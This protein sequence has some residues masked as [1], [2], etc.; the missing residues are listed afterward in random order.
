MAHP[1]EADL[2]ALLQA[3]VGSGIEFIVVGGAA[4][5]LQGAP[6]TTQDLDIVHRRTAG[7]VARLEQL[8]TALDARIR[9]PAGRDLRPDVSHLSGRGQL[10]LS[11]SLGPLDPRCEIHDGRGYEELLPRSEILTDGSTR[12][13]V[14]DLPTPIEVK[15]SA[16]RPKDRIVVPILLALLAEREREK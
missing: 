9:D 16:G 8:L 2:D 4:A 10:N 12:L 3:L 6:T 15:A 1:K 5:V 11:T 13:R 14:L 7:N